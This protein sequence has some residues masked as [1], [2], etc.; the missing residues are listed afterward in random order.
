M[1]K[2]AVVAL[3]KVEETKTSYVYVVVPSGWF[4]D[5]KCSYPASLRA[6]SGLKDRVFKLGDSLPNWPL[7]DAVLIS[8]TGKMCVNLFNFGINT[9]LLF[10]INTTV[11]FAGPLGQHQR[12][13]GLM[14]FQV[15]KLTM[16]TKGREGK[17]QNMLINQMYCLKRSLSLKRRLYIH[18]LM[19]IFPTNKLVVLFKIHL[20]SQSLHQ[21]S[22]SEQII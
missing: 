16:S 7:F 18:P 1:K 5:G 2:Y 11:P 13:E 10:Q 19:Y 15:L 3:K 21:V 22:C 4:V 20:Q 12:K 17:T 14:S 6:D 8:D 9:F